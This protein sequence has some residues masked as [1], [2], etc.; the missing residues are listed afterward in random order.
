MQLFLANLCRV[1]GA[2]CSRP[3]HFRNSE[4]SRVCSR[5]IFY[6]CTET[7][8]F[9]FIIENTAT[10]KLKQLV[11]LKRR[12]K[13]RNMKRN[14]SEAAARDPAPTHLRCMRRH[15]RVQFLQLLHFSA[16][17]LSKRTALFPAAIELTLK[18][19]LASENMDKASPGGPKVEAAA[20]GPPKPLVPCTTLEPGSVHI[21]GRSC[22]ELAQFAFY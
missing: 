20:E 12:F 18:L 5:F 19:L 14:E 17:S 6:C 7:S 16:I 9:E 1:G 13:T 15:R 11:V 2:C 21:G 10:E 22:S 3:T 4:T 8:D